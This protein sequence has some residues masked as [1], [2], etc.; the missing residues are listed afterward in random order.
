MLLHNLRELHG[1]NEL[2]HKYI[3]SCVIHKQTAVLTESIGIKA[4]PNFVMVKC[5]FIAMKGIQH[6]GLKIKKRAQPSLPPSP[7]L[8]LSTKI[9]NITNLEAH[10]PP[11]AAYIFTR[12]TPH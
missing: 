8:R 11:Q 2:D 6:V 5:R 10:V 3:D 7:A 12:R 9:S 1:L 4:P